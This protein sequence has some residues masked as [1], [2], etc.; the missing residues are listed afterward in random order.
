MTMVLALMAQE[1]YITPEQA[2]QSALNLW[3][4]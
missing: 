2:A 1:G 4:K 3:L